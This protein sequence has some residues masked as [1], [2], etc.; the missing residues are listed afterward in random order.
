MVGYRIREGSHRR[1]LLGHWLSLALVALA[2]PSM[3]AQ[4]TVRRE[5]QVDG[6]TRNDWCSSLRR[7]NKNRPRWCLS[8]MATEVRVA[9]R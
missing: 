9:T 4:E 7:P 6:I 1:P 2:C 5:W 3:R 8:S